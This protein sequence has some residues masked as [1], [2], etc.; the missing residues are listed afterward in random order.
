MAS[1]NVELRLDSFYYP[2][3]TAS[4][5]KHILMGVVI[6]TDVVVGGIR[7]YRSFRHYRSQVKW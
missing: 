3:L 5:V 1:P 7:R 6:T 4:Q 2:K